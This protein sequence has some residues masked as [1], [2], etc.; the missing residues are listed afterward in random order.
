MAVVQEQPTSLSK[1]QRAANIWRSFVSLGWYDESI[2]FL[3]KFVAKTSEP[4][5]AAGLVVSAADFL[6]DGQVMRDNPTL[7]LTWSWTQA[8]AIETSAGV[9]LVYAFQSIRGKDKA[10]VWIYGILA[11]L[12]ALVGMTM[13]FLQ[14]IAHSIGIGET[15]ITSSLAWLPYMMSALR[16][17]VAVGYVVMCRTKNISFS[18]QD[19]GVPK[20]PDEKPGISQEQLDQ[21]KN[22]LDALMVKRFEAIEQRVVDALQVAQELRGT[23]VNISEDTSTELTESTTE[24]LGTNGQF[25]ALSI[26]ITNETESRIRLEQAYSEMVAN[27]ERLTG[28]GLAERARVR[29]QSAYDFLKGLGEETVPREEVPA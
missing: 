24:Q 6:S 25:K 18:G 21:V 8:I 29:R 2:D 17:L 12:L 26:P 9:T 14:L 23:V 16:S 7:A 22:D 1:W 19:D 15:Q 4:L 28:A 13:L 10:K 3:F 5:L 11:L 27:Q 20:V